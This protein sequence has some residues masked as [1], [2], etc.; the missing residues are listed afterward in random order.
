M[1]HEAQWPQETRWG[2]GFRSPKR[3][4]DGE[5]SLSG[6]EFLSAGPDSFGKVAS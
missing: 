2:G 6:A 3:C 1:S 5:D 4:Q